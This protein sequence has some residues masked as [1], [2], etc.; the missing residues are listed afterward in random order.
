[1]AATNGTMAVS[2]GGRIQ[3]KDLY[4]SDTVN[5]RV[6]HDGGAG[7]AATS[8]TDFTPTAPCKI[9][10]I[11]IVTGAAQTKLQV[12]INGKA[13]GSMLRHTLH[14]NT[15]AF[16]AP[17]SIPLNAGDKFELVQLA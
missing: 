3:P 1:M 14:L 2:Y 8:P 12:M 11:A 13:E 6:N 10:D 5:T 4:L 15:L 9:V 16:R 17:V 7:A